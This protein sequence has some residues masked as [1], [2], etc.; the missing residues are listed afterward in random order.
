[1]STGPTAYVLLSPNAREAVKPLCLHNAGTLR[2]D[3][4][5]RVDQPPDDVTALAAMLQGDGL[6]AHAY[7][8]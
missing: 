7:T 3:G 2:D 6:A 4:W 1:M 8:T 5:Y